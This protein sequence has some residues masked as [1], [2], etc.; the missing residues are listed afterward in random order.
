MRYKYALLL[1]PL[2]VI[3]YLSSVILYL[4]S[5]QAELKSDLQ[6]VFVYPNPVRVV[7]GH[8]TVT[9]ENLTNNVIIRIV[10][11]NGD[12]VREINVTDTNGVADWDLTNDQGQRVGSG[13]YLYV[14]TNEQGQK[15]KGKIAIIR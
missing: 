11:I 14:I 9:F 4:P 8:K 5:V 12:I 15:A 6:E 7:L 3:C 1:F 2:F 10:K 13:V